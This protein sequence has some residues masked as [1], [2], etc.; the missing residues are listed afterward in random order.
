MDELINKMRLTKTN[1]LNMT[2]IK[3][4]KKI[5]EKHDKMGHLKEIKKYMESLPKKNSKYNKKK[6]VIRN[7]LNTSIKNIEVK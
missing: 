7:H 4:M 1:E 2:T 5:I 6:V 3:S